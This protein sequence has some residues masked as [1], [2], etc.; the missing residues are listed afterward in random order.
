M[1]PVTVE[2][3]EPIETRDWTATIWA[4]AISCDK[5]LT[6]LNRK[7]FRC[8]IPLGPFLFELKIS[9]AVF[10]SAWFTSEGELVNLF[11]FFQTSDV[12]LPD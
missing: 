8:R 4:T 11:S 2:N 12:T 1:T 7:R 6:A 5:Q 10:A 3:V 9:V